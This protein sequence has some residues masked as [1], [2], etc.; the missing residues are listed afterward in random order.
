MVTVDIKV[1]NETTSLYMDGRLHEIL[2]KQVI[3]SVQKKDWDWF[4]VVDGSEGCQP[5]GSKILL[6]D[7]RW[8]N[9]EKIK[10]GDEILSPQQDGSHI[11]SKVTKAFK[12]FSKENYDVIQLNRHKKKLYTCSSNHLIPLNYKIHPRINGN[13]FNKDSYWKIKHYEAKDYYKLSKNSTKKNTTTL[14]SFPISKF[15]NRKNCEIEP[16]TLGV[17]LGDGSFCNTRL[18]I[19]SD[20]QEVINEV[21]KYYN[22]MSISS[23]KNTTAKSY[24]FSKDGILGKQLTKCGLYEKRSGDKFIPKKALLSDLEYR[25]SLLAGLIDTDGYYNKNGGYEIVTK[26]LKLAEGM[27]NLICSIGGRINQLKKIKK[28]IKRI[29]FIGEYYLLSFYLGNIKIPLK[30][31]RKIKDINSFY[32]S[33]NRLA[34]D[35]I[36]SKP[37]IVYGFQIDSKSQWYITDNWT[38]TH[39]SG[40]SVFAFQLAKVLDKNFNLENIVY[41]HNDFVKAVIK[42]KKHSCIV[43]DEAF[44]GLSSR[45]SLT[46]VNQI[47]VSLMMEMRQKNLFIIIVMPT[48]FM[49]EKYMVVHRTKGLFHIYLKNGKRGRWRFYNKVG[50]KFLYINGKKYFDYSSQKPNIFGKFLD[51]YTINEAE[52]RRLKQKTLGR[53]RRMTRA[54]VYKHQRDTLFWIFLKECSFSQQKISN[55]CKKWEYKIDRST[56]SDIYHEKLKEF[57]LNEQSTIADEENYTETPQ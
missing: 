13:R 57:A 7:G 36:K 56:I 26:S 4:V 52:Y 3:P 34:I 40:K 50:T 25:K 19:T 42:A 2:T 14:T 24:S 15:K 49:L 31:K 27:Q 29:N 32:I 39:N 47:L 18:N 33:P 11:Y 37:G 43:F 5:E 46:E 21:N 28:G 30:I 45:G 53:K 17:F 1:D 23:K 9:I 8:K 38:I 48:F 12:W 35:L 10:V 16:Y 51:K 20:D 41:N 55:L 22:L 44:N 54:E 6:S